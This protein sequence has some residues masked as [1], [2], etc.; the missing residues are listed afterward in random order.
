V[1]LGHGHYAA[2]A[3]SAAIESLHAGTYRGCASALEAVHNA[4]RHTRGAAAAILEI[5]WSRRVVAFAGV[6]NV[7]A[8][9]LGHEGVRRQTVSHNGTL[10]HQATHFRE[11]SYPWDRQGLLIMHSDGL[12]SHWSLDSYRGLCLRHPAIIAGVLYRDFNRGRD[13]VTV[14]V[15]REQV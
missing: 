9:L 4:L 15:G 3:A 7:S 6:G 14:I 13:D 12:V 2:G 1:G 11:Y 5:H 8:A 10:G